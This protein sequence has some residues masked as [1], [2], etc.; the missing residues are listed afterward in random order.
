[1]KV[2][3]LIENSKKIIPPYELDIYIPEKNFAIEYN[4]LYWHS[5]QQGKDKDYHLKKLE[6]CLKKGIQL[7]Q[8]FEDEWIFK[9]EIVE[10]RIK[11]LLNI[12]DAPR[13]HAR[14]CDIKIIDN[15]TKND[16]LNSYHLQGQDISSI[17]LGAFYENE[18]VSVM[19]FSRGSIAKGAK[20]QEGH[21]ELNRFCSNY[22]FH[23][24]GIASKF[25]SFFK[26][27]YE[28]LRIYSYAD[29]RWSQGNVYKVL[30]FVKEH[31]TKPNYW[32]IKNYQ[33]IHRYGLRKRSDEP[34]DIPEWVLRLKEGYNRIWDC[35]VIKFSLTK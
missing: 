12:N 27:N 9:K 22:N 32:Y 3:L 28:W 4:G 18:L 35:G 1:M 14:Q 30:G 8:L 19:T 13:I 11:Q 29:R 23:V 20:I 2:L 17:R 5:E 26:R 31:C 34:R 24:P 25:L 21:W 15:N 10:K 33:R 7:I 16:F 6:M